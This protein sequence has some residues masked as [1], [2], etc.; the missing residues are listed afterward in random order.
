MK[1]KL[2]VA[3]VDDRLT[4]KVVKAARAHGATG[5]TIIPAARGEGLAAPQGIFGLSVSARRD[6]ALFAVEE[7]M[8]RLILEEIC[9]AGEFDKKSGAGIA[10]QLGL[11][12]VAGLSSQVDK[13]ARDLGGARHGET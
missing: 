3:F 13:L 9:K 7:R 6:I 4:D 10:I 11:E 1:F 2:I 12:D 5:A 8:S